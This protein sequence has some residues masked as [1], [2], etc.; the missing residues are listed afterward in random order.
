MEM[1]GHTGLA[2]ERL[3][4]ESARPYVARAR[5]AG[6]LLATVCGPG[7][8][9][10]S[11]GRAALVGKLVEELL[12][13]LTFQPGEQSRLTVGAEGAGPP[14]RDCPRGRVMVRIAVEGV[15]SDAAGHE[16]GSQP[17]S[18]QPERGSLGPWP[19]Q[20]RVLAQSLGGDV[21]VLADCGSRAVLETTFYPGPPEGPA[22]QAGAPDGLG[23]DLPCLAGL[24]VLVVDDNAFNLEVIE[25]ILSMTGIQVATVTGGSQALAALERDPDF[26]VVLMDM[27]MPGMDGCEAT[28][29]MRADSR[30][31][32]LPVL[33][34]TANT[35]PDA[36]E[37]CLASGMDDFLVKPVETPA[38]LAALARWGRR[39]WRSNG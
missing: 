18:R 5:S 33:A 25:S 31:R 28:R 10:V 19:G 3:V 12:S 23:H 7:L 14:D 11:P 8:P 2:L 1:N 13:L 24:R 32:G 39:R 15:L 34:L 6:A 21:R 27:Q 26:D 37:Q 9:H 22:P 17:L 16:S 20:S 29:R 38:L 36:R 30:L 35:A 4:E